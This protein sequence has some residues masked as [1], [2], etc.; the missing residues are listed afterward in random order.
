[1]DLPRYR[2]IADEL[3]ARIVAGEYA[4]GDK[5][6]A[7]LQLQREF[8]VPGINTVRHAMR[9]LADQGLVR[10]E[11]G[12]GTFVL[13]A[14]Y[15]DAGR[16][17]LL[18]TLRQAREAVNRAITYLEHA[19][20]VA[21][22]QSPSPAPSAEPAPAPASSASDFASRPLLDTIADATGA[23]APD[24]DVWPPTV[25]ALATH[26]NRAASL[27]RHGTRD[28]EVSLMRRGRRRDAHYVTEA[29]KI[30]TPA[31]TSAAIHDIRRYLTP[32]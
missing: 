21:T 28:V 3:R 31:D 26:R 1:M 5:L 9:V 18:A 29:V 6:P 30:Y 4:V 11:P 2:L 22:E 25:Y 14:D 20:P 32:K 27:S 24:P 8:D 19:P 23:T 17:D 7:L 12:R 16:D 15:P 10:T 13:S